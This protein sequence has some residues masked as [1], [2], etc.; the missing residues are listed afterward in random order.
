MEIIVVLFLTVGTFF[1]TTATIGLLRFPDMFT[2]L[3]ATG[4]GDTLGA[5]LILIGLALL[6][7]PSVT[8]IKLFFIMLFI[9]LTSPVATH[10]ICRAVYHKKVKVEKGGVGI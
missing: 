7:A 8:S 10:C 2:R 6:S 5:S 4:K 1:F 9:L 3:H